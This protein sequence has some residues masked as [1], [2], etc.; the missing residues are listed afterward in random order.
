MSDGIYVALSGAIAQTRNLDVIANNVANANTVGFHGDRV[1]FSQALSQAGLSGPGPDAL[2]FVQADRTATD[3]SA[4]ALEQTGGHL[5]LAL[6][7]DGYFVVRGARGDRY[8]RAGNFVTDADGVLRSHDGLAVMGRSED[9]Q[10]SEPAQIRIPRDAEDVTI[11]RDG[12]VRADGQEVGRLRIV[13]LTEA[14]KEGF[15]LFTAQQATITTEARV[16]QGYLEGSNVNAVSGMVA[17]I[18]ATR[19]FDALQKVI[20]AFRS[21]DERSARDLAGRV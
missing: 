16:E 9:P 13:R 2:R 12:I 15:T 21:V 19:S 7:G 5:D 8:T 10:Q 4:G 14:Q 3:S 18:N 1:A 11:T 20:D 17:L 6:S